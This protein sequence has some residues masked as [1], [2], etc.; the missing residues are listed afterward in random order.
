MQTGQRVGLV[1]NNGAG[2]TTQL[3]ILAGELELDEGEV[4]KSRSDIKIAMLRQEFREDLRDSRSL[5][6]EFISVFSEIEELQQQYTEAEEALANAG[7]DSDAMQAR[8]IANAAA[9]A[10]LSASAP[11][12]GDFLLSCPRSRRLSIR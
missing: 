9:N 2:K 3:R 6:E 10:Q 8:N 7:D 4:I 5:K 1:G 12:S 11:L